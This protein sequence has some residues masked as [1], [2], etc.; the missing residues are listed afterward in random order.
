MQVTQVAMHRGPSILTPD[1]SY[2]RMVRRP[3]VTGQYPTHDTI[4]PHGTSATFLKV[5]DQDS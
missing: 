2:R 1:L 3:S 5:N 4:E